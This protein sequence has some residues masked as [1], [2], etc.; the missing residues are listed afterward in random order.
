MKRSWL[1]QRLSKPLRHNGVG[2]P[3]PY[4][5]GG[6]LLNGG[7]TEEAAKLTAQIWSFDYMGAA[8]FEHGAVQKTLFNIAEVAKAGELKA[9]KTVVW[10]EADAFDAKRDGLVDT[11]GTVYILCPNDCHAE[12]VERVAGWAH[13]RTLETRELRTKEHIGINSALV[14]SKYACCGWLELDNGFM[15]FTDKEMFDNV[16]QLFDIGES[17]PA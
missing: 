15:F 9:F 12:V 10:A 8:E 16:C 13:R 1:I 17:V 11:N 2:V 5:F 4:S 6:G 7:L 3:N 14:G